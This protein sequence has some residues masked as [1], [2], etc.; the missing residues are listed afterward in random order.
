MKYIKIKSVKLHLGCDKSYR[1]GWVNVDFKNSFKH[2]I[3][4]DLNKFPWPFK[5]NTF[6]ELTANN[7]IEHLNNPLEVMKEIWRISKPG[8]R[9][10]IAVPYY[11]SFNAFRDLT[12]VSFFTWDSFS[13]LCGFISSREKDK[14]GY[15]PKLF[16]YSKRKLIYMSSSKFVI[17]QICQFFELIININPEY[18]ERYAPWLFDILNPEAINLRLE[19][20]K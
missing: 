20:I 11:K 17:R 5:D 7:V 2:D 18:V 4:H 3:D 14:V 12:H 8:A 16:R 19:V 1:E 6:E 15:L 10:N 13:P 9:V